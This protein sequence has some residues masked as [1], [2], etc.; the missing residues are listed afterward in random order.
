VKTAVLPSG[1]ERRI[2]EYED[3]KRLAQ[4]AGR[5]LVEVMD[6]VRS[7]LHESARTTM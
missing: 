2:P 3:L 4:A 7:F 6:E 5:P 1:E